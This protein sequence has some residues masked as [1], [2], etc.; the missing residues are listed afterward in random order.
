MIKPEVSIYIALSSMHNFAINY[1]IVLTYDLKNNNKHIKEISGTL[2][3]TTKTRVLLYAIIQALRALNKSC[4][5]HFY[6]EKSERQIANINKRIQNKNL[7][8]L[9]S[10]YDL[11]KEI[12]KFSE[13]HKIN[14]IRT[15]TKD[16]YFVKC[17]NNLN[18]TNIIV[19][20]DSYIP[21]VRNRSFLISKMFESM[22]KA[23]NI[24][25]TNNLN[26]IEFMI[27]NFVLTYNNI[28]TEYSIAKILC[29]SNLKYISSEVE[30]SVYFGILKKIYSVQDIRFAI[31][32]LIH[33]KNLLEEVSKDFYS[34]SSDNK[35]YIAIKLKSNLSEQFQ[36]EIKLI[37]G[38]ILSSFRRKMEGSSSHL[39]YRVSLRS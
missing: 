14:F 6:L 25:L 31:Y 38:L 30:E 1:S 2:K 36:E 37:G 15:D 5:V 33:K 7:E 35:K 8:N 13:E 39:Y 3:K 20:E 24:K 34:P 12:F 9:S 4:I 10:S 11:W 21:S 26:I 23:N 32:N 16:T 29:G 17:C 18:K 27:L 28:Y 22:L 19:R